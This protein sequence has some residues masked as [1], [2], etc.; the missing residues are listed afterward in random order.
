MLSIVLSFVGCYDLK[1]FRHYPTRDLLSKGV[2]VKD[3]SRLSMFV[4]EGVLFYPRMI[5][6]SDS[7]SSP[8]SHL[9]LGSELET[10]IY[11]CEATLKAEDGK[12]LSLVKID[13]TILVDNKAESGLYQAEG[14]PLFDT[15]NVDVSQLLK[16]NNVFLDVYYST[17]DKGLDPRKKISFKLEKREVK[18]ISW[19]T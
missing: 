5:T 17:C 19:S 3:F 8:Y 12:L 15:Q 7:N 18:E 2:K 1:Y 14:V 4:A 9:F 16:H 13:K 10:E 6:L 11:L